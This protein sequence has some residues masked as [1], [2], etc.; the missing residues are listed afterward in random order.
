M[1]YNND[2]IMTYPTTTNA[3]DRGHG[4]H[5]LREEKGQF[6]RLPWTF[7]LGLLQATGAFLAQNQLLV[8]II[9]NRNHDFYL[10]SCPRTRGAGKGK[11]RGCSLRVAS[12]N[13]GTLSSKLLE[14]IDALKRRRVQIACLQETRWKGHRAEERNGYKLLYSGSD[15]AKNGVGF[16]VSIEL[17]KNV[18]EVI[19]HNDR[20]MVLRLVLGEQVVTV[21]CAYAPQVELGEQEK[22]EFWDCLDVVV[23]AIPRE[24]KIFIGGDFNGHIGKDSDGF[25]LVHGGFGFSDRNDPGRDLLDFAAAHS[26]GIINSFFRKRESH[27]ITFSSGGRNTQI[28][29]LLMRQEDRRM[30]RD[31]KVIPRETAA[32]QHHLLVA[33]IAIKEG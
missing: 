1:E 22:K 8:V 2:T 25:E 32:A 5:E 28:D 12:W 23:R 20:I 18:I 10:R 29:Y 11:V 15:G 16:L 3:W 17:H 7:K 21:V 30:W 24:E 19:R 6:V 33:D 26:L 14:V 4:A 27:L 31:C 9:D 13:V